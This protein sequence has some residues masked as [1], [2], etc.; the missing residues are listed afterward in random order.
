ML[1]PA[2]L[3]D[4]LLELAISGLYKAHWSPDIHEEWIRAILRERPDL[5]ADKLARTRLLMDQ[6]SEDALVGGYAPLIN[7][8]G[9]FKSEVQHLGFSG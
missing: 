4:L 6:H 9:G 1:Y 5:T 3:R 8:L 7:S 2:P